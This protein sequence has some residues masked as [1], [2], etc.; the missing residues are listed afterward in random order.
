MT[1]K[2]SRRLTLGLAISAL[3][4]S[5]AV[6]AP[7]NVPSI[8][9]GKKMYESFLKDG[10][11]FSYPGSQG[12]PKAVMAFDTQCPDCMKI[13]KNLQPLL[14]QVDI[15]FYPIAY[16]NIHSE[17]QGST[18]LASKEPFKV[19]EQQHEH[20]KDPGFRGIRY[21]LKKLPDELRNKVWTNT[22]L[23]RRSGCRAVPYGV[24]K[25]SKGEYVPF[26]ENMTTEELKKLFELN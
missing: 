8:W 19:F 7:A 1:L 4:G 5:A 14:G 20:F 16:L 9:E 10:T 13:Y 15:I 26:D 17:P 23:H 22:K 12:K 3:F 24:F 21:D 6:A 11:G 25:N 18:I 2:L